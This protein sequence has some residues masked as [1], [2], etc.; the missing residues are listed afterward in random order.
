VDA[1][2]QKCRFRPKIWLESRTRS[3]Q[4]QPDELVI[5]YRREPLRDMCRKAGIWRLGNRAGLSA[6]P[7]QLAPLAP[8]A[9]TDVSGRMQPGGSFKRIE[10]LIRNQQ[11]IGSNPIAGSTP[12]SG[13]GGCSPRCTRS[14]QEALKLLDRTETGQFLCPVYGFGAHGNLLV[15]R[16]NL[17]CSLVCDNSCTITIGE[18]NP[19]RRHWLP[20]KSAVHLTRNAANQ[21]RFKQS[22]KTGSSKR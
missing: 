8:S 5:L 13:S 21:L 19:R 3:L 14:A 11:V 15:F 7:T 4:T 12:R 2:P 20:C 6:I 10:Q 1:A 17:H 18:V 9:K 16:N 22:L